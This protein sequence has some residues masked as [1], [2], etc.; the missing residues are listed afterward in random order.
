MWKLSEHAL[1]RDRTA[2]RPAYV[3]I[4]G[5]DGKTVWGCGEHHDIITASIKGLISAINRRK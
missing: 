3:G 2:A 1:R 4:A 5:D